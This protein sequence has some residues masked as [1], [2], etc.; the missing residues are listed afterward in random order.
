MTCLIAHNYNI[1][2][3]LVSF[4][5][6]ELQTKANACVELAKAAEKSFMN[7]MDLSGEVRLSAILDASLIVHL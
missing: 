3:K 5:L 2:Q 6:K 1:T 7:V 4:H